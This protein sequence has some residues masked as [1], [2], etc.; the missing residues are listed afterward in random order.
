[1]LLPVTLP[2]DP[3]VLQA[4]K[5]AHQ[6]GSTG[7][8]RKA[9][10]R[11]GRVLGKEWGAKTGDF[12]EYAFSVKGNAPTRMRVRYAR[13]LAGVA[14]LR[15]LLDGKVA[16]TLK[17]RPTGGW[18]DREEQFGEAS[19]ALPELARGTHRLR[20]TVPPF[21]P[22]VPLRKLPPVPVLDLVGN[23]A[24]KNTAG[25]GRQVAL[26]TGAPSKFYYATQNLTNVFSAA[27]GATLDWAPDHVL[28][29]PQGDPPANVNLDQIT[30]DSGSPGDAAEPFN[31][32]FEQRQVCVTKDDVVV[33]RIALTNL[34]DEA[35]R[36]QVP[37]RGDCRESR[38][39]RGRPGGQKA[40]RQEDGVVLLTDRNVFP[41]VLPNGLSIAVG[42]TLPPTSVNVDTP[43]A[44]EVTYEVEVPARESVVFIAACAINR[45]EAEAKR[46][47][48]KTL[49]AAAPLHANRSD[50]KA[51]FESEVPSFTSSD[52]ALDELYAFRWFLL[53]F[54]RAGGDLGYLKYPVV[55]EGRQEFQTYCCYSAPFMAF[56]LNWA[57]DPQYGYGHLAN[58]AVA[59][60]E[61]G[62]FP[63]YAT[64][65]TNR[66]PL[67]HDSATGQSALPWTVW[68]HYE[69]H[70]RQ[71]LIEP[72][73]P[74]MRKNVDWWIADRDPD[75]N[76]LFSIDHQLET[77]MDDLHRRWKGKAPKRYE[78]IDA[79]AYAILNLRAVANMARL[80][81]KPDEAERYDAYATKAENAL[82]TL[83]WDPKL[84]RYRDRN[85]DDGELTDYNSITIFYPFFA[86]VVSKESL[87]LI[88]RYLLNPKEYATPAP[89][90][91]LSKSDKEYD[92]KRR[93]WAG[94][95]WPATNSHVAEAFIATAK[96]HDRAHLPAAAELFRKVAALHMRPR[97]DFYEHYDSLT[98]EPKS[99][100]RDYMHS[101][102]I[103]LYVRHVAG[104]T[105]QP[106]GSLV[107]D[108]LPLGLTHFALRNAPYAG[109]RVDVEFAGGQLTVRVDGRDVRQEAGFVPG[110]TPLTIPATEFR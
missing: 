27:D 87:A 43:G 46:A 78:A 4:A 38:D 12:A 98:G 6:Q 85:P 26:Y 47:L 11:Y 2:A 61:D 48:R 40:S 57:G 76:G 42:A 22:P 8:D 36:Y 58:M 70:R 35:V 63:W 104:M 60:Y 91:A 21:E 110:G 16:G 80:L 96:A 31:P 30:L 99:T 86:G 53:H 108:P 81:E 73:Y 88:D 97:A 7:E 13:E 109:R 45:D 59:A 23:R 49:D 103:D 17:L 18:G 95:T 82:Q 51:F 74:A 77:G 3:I 68:R 66:V 62:R 32:V 41:S 20:L 34:T 29:T 106:D 64:P 93:Y 9:G 101:W 14:T 10:S 55:L 84:Q 89:V 102:W 72:L 52:K 69:I 75:G 44:Y 50:W 79:T 37:V 94:P 100:F 19:L 1:M 33:S 24:D 90:P 56:D 5:P 28:V 107:I 15:V 25:H 71:D 83:M 105:P 67:D 54:S 39:Y 65:E 92:T